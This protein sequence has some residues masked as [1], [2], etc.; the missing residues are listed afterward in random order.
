[1]TRSLWLVLVA[2]WLSAPAVRADEKAD[3]EGVEFFEKRIRPL[4]IKHCYECHST[5]A[6]KLRGELRLDT[7]DGVRKGGASGPAVVPGDPAKSLLVKVVNHTDPA[8]RM[9]PKGPLAAAEIADLEAWVKRGA[10]D[11]RAGGTAPPALDLANARAFWAFRPVVNPPVPQVG[12]ATNPVDSFI[13][14]TLSDKGLS[15]TP[16]ADRRT[17][18]RR[19]TFDLTGLPPTSEEVDTFL[20]DESPDAFAKVV[21]RLLASRTYGERWGRHWLDVVRYADTA[22]DNSDYP[23]PQMYRYRNWVIDAFNRDLPY[24]EFVRQQLA[25]DL[26]PASD[27]ADRQAKLIATGY[28]ANA[29]RFGSYE[30]ARYPWHLTI[31]DTIDNLGRA[32]LGLTL[33]CCRCHDHKFD[34]LPQTDYYAL[35]GF[36]SSTRYPRPGIE[37]DKAQRDFVPLA[38]PARVAAVEAERAAKLTALEG[39]SKELDAVRAAAEALSKA[40][41][42]PIRTAAFGRIASAAAGWVKVAKKE[43]DD[44]SKAPLPFESAYAVAEGVTAGKRKVGNAC[45]QVKGDPERL[46]PEVPRRFPLVLGGQTLSP[47]SPGSGR[48]QLANWVTDPANPLTARVMVNRIWQGHFGKGIV[49]TTGNFGALG[50]PPTH[51]EL[52]DYLAARFVETGWSVKAAHRL[53]ML[54]RTYQMSGTGDPANERIDPTNEYFWRFDRRRLDA[55]SIRD[56]LLATAGTLDRTSGGPHPFPDPRAW[57]FTQHK[58]FKGVYESNRRSVYLMTQRIQRHPFLALFD[59]PDTNA[60]TFT[61]VT[62]T[63]PLQALYLMNDPFVHAQAA[64]LAE[65]VL[66]ERSDDAARVERAYRLLYAR[67]PTAD[68]SVAALDYLRRVKAKAADER[69]AW[70]S[71]ARALYLGNE[72]VY[73]D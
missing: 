68:E 29:R 57:D 52:L 59:G 53:I 18:I 25:G 9:P 44:F 69:G 41:G 12:G 40:G 22:G 36:F 72:F 4:L 71:F 64:K 37:L 48:L 70:A 61:R 26:L 31:E 3:H 43:R 56:S 21:D 14:R 73:V 33:G 5:G 65:R 67:P 63:T 46:G 8:E 66:A 27:E 1:M 16:A 39:R 45:V 60:G 30:D 7:R 47:G 24:N 34:P 42:H 62:S 49:R 23:I 28:L 6:K 32:F 17:L 11:P 55:E 20:R 10:P 54:S 50:R 13:L 51:P 2:V 35:Y 38:P 58:P 19:A 15:P